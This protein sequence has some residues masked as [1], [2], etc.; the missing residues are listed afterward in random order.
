MILGI[1]GYPQKK[2]IWIFYFLRRLAIAST[3]FCV[4]PWFFF[5]ISCPF[6]P[7]DRAYSLSVRHFLAILYSLLASF[8]CIAPPSFSRALTVCLKLK[9]CGPKMVHFPKA[10]G[11]IMSEPPIGV[12][13][14][15]TNTTV[16]IA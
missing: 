14:L 12:R 11:S 7:I 16:A 6:V 5:I 1:Y 9:V 4:A 8:T 3:V 13:V 15:P 2:R 10:V